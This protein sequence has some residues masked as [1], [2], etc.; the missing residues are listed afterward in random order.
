MIWWSGG[1]VGWLECANMVSGWN[2]AM[3]FSFSKWGN[4]ESIFFAHM[5]KW[6]NNYM[7]KWWYG[8]IVQWLIVFLGHI[9]INGEM[10]KRWS[11]VFALEW[12]FSLE[13]L[14]FTRTLSWGTI[15]VGVNV[16]FPGHYLGGHVPWDCPGSFCD[17][18]QHLTT[19]DTV[20]GRNF[21]R[22]MPWDKLV[23]LYLRW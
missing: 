17:P 19:P 20:L 3:V 14:L 2:G 13:W 5:V 11:A 6:W 22:E 4:G 18:W 8:E 9:S 21:P 7:V 12:F 1:M 15:F 16:F 10:I 23:L